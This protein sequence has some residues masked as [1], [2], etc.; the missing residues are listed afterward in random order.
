MTSRGTRVFIALMIRRA[1]CLVLASL[2]LVSSVDAGPRRRAVGFP[3]TG[4]G[5]ATPAGWLAANAHPLNTL[6]LVPDTSD[7]FPLRAMIGSSEMVALG[8]GTHG[9]HEFYT[10]KLRVLDYLVR[11]MGFDVLAFEA[12]FPLMNRIDAYVQGGAGDARAMLHEMD[13]LT[14]FFWDAEEIVDVVEWMREYNAHRG[15]RPALHIAGADV[16]QPDAA[17]NAV[18][19]YLRG[20][21][22]VAAVDAEERYACAREQT[23]VIDSNCQARAAKVF[24]VLVT[25]EAEWTAQSSAG[26]FD[27]ALHY[28]RVVVQSRY[29][30]GE[31]RDESLA[32]NALWLREH[33]GTSGK[34]ITSQ[35]PRSPRPARFC[36]G[37][38]RRARATSSSSRARSRRS[39]RRRTRATSARAASRI[40]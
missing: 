18:V 32:E 13:A 40:C 37:K 12:P 28:A 16:T 27:E 30:S 26:A 9:T 35:S 1:G 3:D 24:A 17:S 34:L 39:S 7:L 21:D 29:G 11:E 6:E 10:V 15:E 25:H 20:V 23:L 22:P 36:S 14:Y 19:A 38:T 8:D 5:D 4:A 33:R 2:V 31:H